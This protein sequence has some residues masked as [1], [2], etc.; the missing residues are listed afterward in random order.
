MPMFD[1]AQKRILLILTSLALSGWAEEAKPLA[2]LQEEF[3]QWK[4]G[5]FLHFNVATFHNQEWANG[6]EDPATFAPGKLDCGQWADAAR[7]AGMNYAA[8]TVKHTGGWCLW[9]SQHTTHDITAF[10]NYKNGK[11]DI[12]REFV[13][14]FRARGLKVCFYY[15]FPGDYDNKYGNTLPAGKPSLHGLPPEAAGD[16]AGFIKK[17]LTELLTNYGSIDM[18]WIDQF[19]NKYTG[20][21]WHEIKSHIKSLQPNCLV[22]ANNSHKDE[23]TDIH[24]YELPIFKGKRLAE[25]LPA[26]NTHPAEV[27]DELGPGWFW[28][29]NWSEQRLMP[30]TEVVDRLRL[31]NGRHAAYLLD[32]GPDTTGR[33]PDCAVKRLQEVG[34][35]LEIPPAKP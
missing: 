11:G 27:C 16:Y 31:C 24:S 3:L 12:V 23:Q 4:F 18:L 35:L 13:D 8:L 9:D 28:N 30:A 14:A 20:K 6:Y 22:I 32:V 33:L 5:L 34:N 15:C 25:V 29:K 17:Q 19:S 10:K 7:A 26:N 1:T 21:Q 2:R